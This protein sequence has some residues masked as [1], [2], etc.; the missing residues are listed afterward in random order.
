VREAESGRGAVSPPELRVRRTHGY[1]TSRPD[2]LAHVP[3]TA[4]NILELGCSVG[5]LGESIKARQGARVL[6]IEVDPDYARE[7]STRIDRVINADLELVAEGPPPP[8]APFDCL[9]A[10]DVLEHLVDPWKIFRQCSGFLQ[11][12]ASVIVSVPNVLY[13]PEFRRVLRGSWPLDAKESTTGPTYAGL[14]TTT[15]LNSLPP[16]TWR[17]FTSSRGTGGT[18]GGSQFAAGWSIQA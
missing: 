6:G 4:R 17:R 9:I 13:W 16:R 15:R 10:A 1:E 5:A 11:A 12:G 14:H 7:A 18:A 8:E 2:I 3:L